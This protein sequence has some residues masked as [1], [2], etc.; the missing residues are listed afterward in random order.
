MEYI[1]K[2]FEDNLLWFEMDTVRG[3]LKVE[4]KQINTDLIYLKPLDLEL[5]N[6]SLSRWL[7]KRVIPRT[8]AY[9]SNFLAKLGLNERDTKGI[10]DI[11]Q[12]LS[13]NDAYWVIKVD[14]NDTFASE[15]LLP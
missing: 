7:R 11:C 14:C 8:R 3:E 4:I 5:T 13:L 9:A 15:N 6:D 12:G 2:H 1:L 10:I